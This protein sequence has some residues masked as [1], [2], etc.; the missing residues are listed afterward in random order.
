VDSFVNLRRV[1]VAMSVVSV[2]GQPFDALDPSAPGDGFTKK[3]AIA[4]RMQSQVIDRLYDFY[5]ALLEKSQQKIEPEQV[6]N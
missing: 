4:K 5:N 2:N 3:L 6:K 1:V